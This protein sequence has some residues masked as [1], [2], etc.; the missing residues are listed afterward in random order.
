MY[1]SAE[2]RQITAHDLENKGMDQ[3]VIATRMRAD[4]SQGKPAVN[5]VAPR[6]LRRVTSARPAR[7]RTGPARRLE[8]DR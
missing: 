6:T 5:A 3:E 4:V 2:R 1:D 8:D 7:A